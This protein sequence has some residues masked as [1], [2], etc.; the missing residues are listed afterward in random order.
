MPAHSTTMIRSHPL[1]RQM[2][3]PPL[4]VAIFLVI[5]LVLMDAQISYRNIRQLYKESGMVTHTYEVLGT[6][7]NIL[8][9]STDAEAGQRGYVITGEAAYLQPYDLALPQIYKQVEF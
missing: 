8:S 2:F 4:L 7:N 5:F 9:L 3:H 1:M 6:L